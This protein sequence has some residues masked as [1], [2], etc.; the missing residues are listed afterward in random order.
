MAR[1]QPDPA[2]GDPFLEQFFARIPDSTARSFTA[3]Q[4]LAIKMAFGARDWGFHTIDLRLSIP[5]LRY[6]LV[7]VMGSEKRS[8]ERRRRDKGF[9]PV[10]T[11]GNG[12]AVLVFMALLAVPIALT[13][14]SVKSG[15]EINL[16][17]DS[18]VHDSLAELKRQ[19][20]L[21]LQ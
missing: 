7:F 3:D 19:I 20:I 4:L 5:L 2:G 11:L 18:G 21:F 9:R 17:E 10:A 15:L 14:Y 1:T 12:F 16:L 13:F 6:Y 8:K